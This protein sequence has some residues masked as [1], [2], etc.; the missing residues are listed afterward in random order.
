MRGLKK[1]LE[2]HKILTIMYF[3]ILINS[4]AVEVLL[5][6]DNIMHWSIKC[7]ITMQTGNVLCV[8]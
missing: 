7:D 8:F 5:V 3:V 4:I 6:S 1:A 2:L